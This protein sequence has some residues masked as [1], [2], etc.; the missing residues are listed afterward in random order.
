M[1]TERK[2]WEERL[3]ALIFEAT[4]TSNIYDIPLNR[5]EDKSKINFD[6]VRGSV[7]IATGRVKTEKEADAYVNAVL[8]TR[9]P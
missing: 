4:G 2:T 8:N 6:R 9:L 1:N 7:R 3:D 5:F